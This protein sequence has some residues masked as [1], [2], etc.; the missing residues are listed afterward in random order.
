MVPRSNISLEVQAFSKLEAIGEP[1]HAPVIW[2]VDSSLQVSLETLTCTWDILTEQQP[3]VPLL[4]GVI[5]AQIRALGSQHVTR[6]DKGLPG[7]HPPFMRRRENISFSSTD[8]VE[9]KGAHVG[10]MALL[11]TLPFLNAKD[12]C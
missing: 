7:P 3:H 12:G 2:K 11:L 4:Q 10:L 6:R 8:R 1:L 5:L 9:R